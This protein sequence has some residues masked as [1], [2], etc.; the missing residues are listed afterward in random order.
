MPFDNVTID[1]SGMAGMQ[2]ARHA[3]FAFYVRELL[4]ENIFLLH[5]ETVGLQ[6]THPLRA[7]ASRR[8]RINGYRW[9]ARYRLRIDETESRQHQD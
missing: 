8:V 7:A 2:S 9:R 5:L 6:V 1:H 3:V 4:A